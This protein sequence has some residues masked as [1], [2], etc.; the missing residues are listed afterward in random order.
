[1]L[2]VVGTRKRAACLEACNQAEMLLHVSG[3]DQ[4]DDGGTA[5]LVDDLV[6]LSG[7]QP[8]ARRSTQPGDSLDGAVWQE[9]GALRGLMQGPA[10]T[11]KGLF[12]STRTCGSSSSRV[13]RASPQATFTA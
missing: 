5:R 10:L 7:K 11:I 9:T 13:M 4:L 12:F 3:E 6:H 1:M 8:Q 2:F